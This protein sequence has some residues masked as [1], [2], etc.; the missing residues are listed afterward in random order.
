[1]VGSRVA[2][3]PLPVSRPLAAVLCGALAI[4]GCSGS[5]LTTLSQNAAGKYDYNT[6]AVPFLAEM[7]KC[8]VSLFMARRA[9]GPTGSLPPL[10]RATAT[11]AF[12]AFLYAIQNNLS[13]VALRLVDVGSFHVLMNLR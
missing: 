11:F 6:T 12:L 13:F 2:S 9:A 1:M 10:G 5:F 8:C 7:A 3:D 4:L